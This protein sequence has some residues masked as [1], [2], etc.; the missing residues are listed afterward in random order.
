MPRCR[1]PVEVAAGKLVSAVQREWGEEAGEPTS[2][3]SE[4]VMH[5]CHSLLQAAKNGSVAT[6]LGGRSVAA[7]LGEGWVR[8]HP[9]VWPHL[10][11]FGALL[12]DE[13]SN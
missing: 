1:T 10:Q 13:P 9:R 2:T 5:A 3:A 6:L 8:K 4:E 11:V 12:L 7:F